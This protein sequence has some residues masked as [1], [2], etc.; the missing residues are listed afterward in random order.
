MGIYDFVSELSQE[1]NKMTMEAFAT[2]GFQEDFIIKNIKD[3]YAVK[4]SNGVTQY[5]YKNKF[6][7]SIEIDMEDCLINNY[8]YSYKSVINVKF[9]KRYK[10]GLKKEE[11]V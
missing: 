9:A 5:F 7:F 11:V 2:C 4:S 6:L 3:F 1:I 8:S 10:D